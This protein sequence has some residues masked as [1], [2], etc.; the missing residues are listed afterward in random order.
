M[1]GDILL[2][3]SLGREQI[4]RPGTSAHDNTETNGEGAISKQVPPPEIDFSLEALKNN[5]KV[6]LILSLYYVILIPT[7]Q[8]MIFCY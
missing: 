3:A 1:L 8:C 5:V 2:S 6:L 4:G 7:Y